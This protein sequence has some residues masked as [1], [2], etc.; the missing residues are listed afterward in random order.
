ME[1]RAIEIDLLRQPRFKIEDRIA[2]TYGL[3]L[4]ISTI[5]DMYTKIVKI[6][7]FKFS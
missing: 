5:R 4:R 7:V 6:D 3:L 2:D 1:K